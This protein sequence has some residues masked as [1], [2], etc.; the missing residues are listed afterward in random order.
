MQIAPELR[1]G[2]GIAFFVVLVLLFFRVRAARS[3]RAERPLSRGPA[4]MRFTCAGCTELFTHTKR[5]LGAWEKGTRR[6]YCNACHTKWRGSRPLQS[7]DAQPAAGRRAEMPS[8]RNPSYNTSGIRH[9]GSG[10][11]CLGVVV[12]L[13]ALPTAIVLVIAQYA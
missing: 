13:I 2:L 7:P 3:R 12:L 5:T 8:P 1:T 6:F 10:G 4:N 11:G 9:A